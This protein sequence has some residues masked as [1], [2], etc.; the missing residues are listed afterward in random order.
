VAAFGQKRPL[1]A[2]GAVIAYPA[3]ALDD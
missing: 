1:R 3:L 2:A